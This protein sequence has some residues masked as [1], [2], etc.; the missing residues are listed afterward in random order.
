MLCLDRQDTP[1]S[2]ER[3]ALQCLGKGPGISGLAVAMEARLC[4]PPAFSQTVPLCTKPSGVSDRLRLP[5]P[6]GK[7]V[8]CKEQSLLSIFTHGLRLSL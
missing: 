2:T 6:R 8:E 5:A 3:V 1:A 7:Y 4:P